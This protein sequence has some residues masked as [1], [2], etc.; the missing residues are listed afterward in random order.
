MTPGLRLHDAAWSEAEIVRFYLR[1]RRRVED[2]Y[3]SERAILEPSLVP[4]R[5]VLDVGCAAGG[6]SEILAALK[7]GLRYAGVD[8]AP[9]MVEAARRRYPALRFDVSE[10]GTLAFEDGAADLVLCT[11]VLHHNPDYEAM[12]RECYRVCRIGCVLDL[13]RLI[14]RPYAFD[15]ATS[16]MRLDQRFEA[17]DAPWTV[18]YVLCN[19]QPMFS[20]LAEGLRPRPRMVAAVGYDGQPDPSVVIPSR[21][22]CFCVAY[23]RKGD[24]HTTRTRLFLEMPPDIVE[25]LRL[26]GVEWLRGDRAALSRFI[27][28]DS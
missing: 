18:P 23:L 24:P 6:F 13:P 25:P 12:I 10:G 2:L 3:D 22:V 28:E 7:P 17:G 1:E 11:S 14:R 20:F 4:C 26:D 21:P 9:A 16:F 5:S 19:P 8:A 15:P 27:S